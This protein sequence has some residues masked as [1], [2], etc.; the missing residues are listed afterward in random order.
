MHQSHARRRPS[1]GRRQPGAWSIAWV[2]QASSNFR[3]RASKTFPRSRRSWRTGSRW[4]RSPS[5]R[6]STTRNRST[7]CEKST[8]STSKLETGN[9]KLAEVTD[10]AQLT[11]SK[12]L[13]YSASTS[14]FQRRCLQRNRTGRTQAG[15][16]LHQAFWGQPWKHNAFTAPK[17]APEF[18][19]AE[20]KAAAARALNNGVRFGTPAKLAEELKEVQ[21]PSTGDLWNCEDCIG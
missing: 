7:G 3:R 1:R 15:Y 17:F 5:T 14:L 13:P 2:K 8:C 4:R 19:P 20:L 12:A 11:S 21:K 10:A 9:S 6:L 18:T 16:R